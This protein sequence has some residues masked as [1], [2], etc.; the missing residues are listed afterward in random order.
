MTDASAQAAEANIETLHLTTPIMRGETAIKEL[1]LRKPKAGELRG[2]SMQELMNARMSAVL[3]ILPRITMPPI[4]QHEADN[5]E[6]E[7]AANA[8][9]II[10]GFFMTSGMRH[11]I[12]KALNR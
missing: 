9:G 10:I 5:L 6:V 2:L 12:E 11:Q 3:D 7:D 1:K 8:S 4:E